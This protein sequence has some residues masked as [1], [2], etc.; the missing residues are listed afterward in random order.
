MTPPT[1]HL[2]ALGTAITLTSASQLLLRTGA[3]RSRNSIMGMVNPWTAGGCTILALV[4]VLM[5]FCL[6]E[7]PLR[8]VVAWNSLT[9]ILTLLAARLFLK[10][11]LTRRKVA[12]TILVVCGIVVFTL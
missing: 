8:T 10:E 6:Q 9:F 4:T 2:V 3:I 7:I 5:V 11:P 12:S 1:A